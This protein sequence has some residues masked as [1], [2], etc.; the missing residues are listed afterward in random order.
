RGC[1]RRRR[2]RLLPLKCAGLTNI[3]RKGGDPG[4]ASHHLHG[5]FVCHGQLCEGLCS[6]LVRSCV[7]RTFDEYPVR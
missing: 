4:Q 6:G 5:Q 3:R 7:E 2:M 1:P